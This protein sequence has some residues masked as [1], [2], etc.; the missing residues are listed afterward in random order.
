MILKT[1]VLVVILLSICCVLSHGKV[2]NDI[3]K[4]IQNLKD[5]TLETIRRLRR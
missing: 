4:E 2:K 1:L 5:E 3:R